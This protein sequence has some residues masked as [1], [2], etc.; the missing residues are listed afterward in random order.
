M[1]Q[2][3][4]SFNLKPTDLISMINKLKNPEEKLDEEGRKLKDTQKKLKEEA[5]QDLKKSQ[6]SLKL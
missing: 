5:M 1:K 3:A 2:F 6:E 4:K